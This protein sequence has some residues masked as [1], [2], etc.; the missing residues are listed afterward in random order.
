MAK[1]RSPHTQTQQNT[2]PEQSDLEPG[3]AE[4]NAGT[5]QDEQIY[6]ENDGAETGSNRSPRFVQTRSEQHNTEPETE[7]HEGSISSRTVDG[8]SQGVT[9][10]ST[11]EENERQRKVV[12]DRPD[13]QAG[14]NHP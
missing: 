14:V 1:Q 12:K 11:E 2:R 4:Y 6:E 10:H 5:G 7:G 3:Q 8:D 9:P 13:A